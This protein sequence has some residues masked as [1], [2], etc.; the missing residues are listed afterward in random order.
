MNLAGGRLVVSGVPVRM[1]GGTRTGI[2]IGMV[3]GIRHWTAFVCAIE[4]KH[5][6]GSKHFYYYY[7]CI[8]LFEMVW[9]V[10]DSVKAPRRGPGL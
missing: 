8:C 4:F 6:C 3:M 10:W 5:E 7:S 1:G 9:F 2:G